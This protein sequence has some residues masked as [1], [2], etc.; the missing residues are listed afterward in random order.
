MPKRPAFLTVADKL[1]PAAHAAYAH[2][3]AHGYRVQVEKADASTPYVPTMTAVR[4]STTV[5]VEVCGVLDLM[6]VK[7]WVSY[8][9]STA[10]D[11]RLMLCMPT[12]ATVQEDDLRQL[13]VGMLRFGTAITE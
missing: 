3:V 10:R 4:S 2:F 11:T 8:S 6:R 5:H 9:K 1:L 13:G 12:E 7:Q